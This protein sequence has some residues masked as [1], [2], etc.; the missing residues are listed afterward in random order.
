MAAAEGEVDGAKGTPGWGEG[1]VEF[2]VADAAEELGVGGGAAS[3][4]SAEG[5]ALAEKAAEVEDGAGVGG[6]FWFVHRDSN[7]SERA[8]SGPPGLVHCLIIKELG[9]QKAKKRART[10]PFATPATSGVA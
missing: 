4:D 8:T 3:G 7:A 9:G 2:F 1:A 10:G 5:A 6:D